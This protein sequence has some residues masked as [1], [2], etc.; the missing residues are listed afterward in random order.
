MG[1]WELHRFYSGDTIVRRHLPSTAV[2]GR[3]SLRRFLGRYGSVYIKPNYEHQGV[4]I[5]KAWK[6]KSGGYT[7]VKVRGSAAAALPS[8]DALHRKLRV[9]SKPI[10]V[11]QEAIPLARAGGRPFDIRVMMM[12]LRGRW[13]Y[14]GMLAKVAGA[15]SV[16][17]NVRRGG[18]YVLTVPDA[19]NKAGQGGSSGKMA[20]LRTLSYRICRRFNRYKYTRQIGIDYGIDRSGKIWVIEVNFDFPSQELFAKL[21]DRSAYR[22][23][24]S[25]AKTWRK[26]SKS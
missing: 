2:Y 10:S 17:T 25:I 4:G 23:I 14:A 1:K 7:Y 8:T 9:R 11:V 16:I 21:K 12:R 22:K 6:T 20:N 24:K 13:T 3:A 5:I 18:G 26:A 15:G 19:L